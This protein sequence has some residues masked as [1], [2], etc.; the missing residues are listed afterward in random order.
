VVEATSV[1][2][3]ALASF[4][5]SAWSQEATLVAGTTGDAAD[6][7]SV[8]FVDVGPASHCGAGKKREGNAL[9]AWSAWAHPSTVVAGTTC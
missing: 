4:A 9:F 2:G 8:L 7:A 6:V 3:A 1:E 5:R